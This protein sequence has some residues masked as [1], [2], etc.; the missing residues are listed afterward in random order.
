MGGLAGYVVAGAVGGAAQSLVDRMKQLHAD[1]MA[2]QERKD[3]F[4][5]ASQEHD[6]RM[7]EI[8]TNARNDQALLG[9]KRGYE[10]QDQNDAL[11]RAEN[12][13]SAFESLFGSSGDGGGNV[14]TRAL[15]AGNGQYSLPD[16]GESLSRTE[17]GGNYGIVNDQGY[18]GKYQFGDERLSDYQR[19]TGEK[20]TKEQF[21]RD[22]KLQERVFDWHKKDIEKF[23]LENGLDRYIGTTINGTP[24]TM[25]GIVAAAHLGGEN[26]AKKFLETNGSYNPAD[27]NGTR[28]SDYMSEHSGMLGKLMSLGMNPG[29]TDGQRQ[30]VSAAIKSLMDNTPQP[31]TPENRYKVVGGTLVDLYGD[32]GPT[33]VVRDQDPTK[34]PIAALRA[35]AAEAGL[36][37]G[38]QAYQQ[39]MA[40]G[41]VSNNGTSLS[42]G[43]DGSVQFS[44]G[45]TTVGKPLT[46]G[47][48]KDNMYATTA[49]AAL[50]R[51]EKY[52][53]ALTSL[54]D[55]ALGVIPM[56][57]GAYAQ[58][59]DYQ[60]GNQAAAEFTAAILRKES[61]AA[62]T[63]SDFE[64]SNA[65]F[66]PQPGDSP[67][68]VKAKITAAK[69]AVSGLQSGMNPEQKASVK[70]AIES[71]TGLPF[72]PET[73]GKTSDG[74]A[75]DST[76]VGTMGNPARV[77]TP[78]DAAKLPSGSYFVDPNGNMRRV[79]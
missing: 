3:K 49:L 71:I 72:D 37:P 52:A 35:R 9:Q 42:V 12:A 69:L 64:Y 74:P 10:V 36:Q 15:A 75:D 29:L 34:D 16:I 76:T 13:Q 46:E 67:S 32:K 54:A 47:Q 23:A 27:S 60:S 6:W 28:L 55:S 62:L 7:E 53:T 21:R 26:G 79:P 73:T 17:S 22:P 78:A 58:S 68:R 66:I 56:N 40:A 48:S 19:A 41:G 20:F 5:L 70:Q 61:G 50:P 8:G 39:F 57:L 31:L 18:T 4:A 30:V 38:T 44:Q 77:A 65:R 2:A 24:V 51:L 45:T 25:D 43:P 63:K 11:K 33:P 14:P 59:D 1:A